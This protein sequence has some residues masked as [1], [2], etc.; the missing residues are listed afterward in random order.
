MNQRQIQYDVM[1]Q[2]QNQ[3]YDSVERYV[4]YIIRDITINHVLSINN[5]VVLAIQTQLSDPIV[6]CVLAASNHRRF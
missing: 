6:R 2:I 1:P 5:N 4:K 3:I